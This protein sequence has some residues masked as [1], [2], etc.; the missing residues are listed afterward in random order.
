MSEHFF[1]EILN[2][3]KVDHESID[4]TDDL[5]EYVPEDE[6]FEQYEYIDIERTPVEITK[7]L[8]SEAGPRKTIKLEDKP[9]IIKLKSDEQF[10]QDEES[11]KCS[12]RKCK[13]EKI[14][15]ESQTDLD[16][17]NLIHIRQI[18][19]NECAI[20]NKVLTNSSKLKSHMETRH[21]P[22]I[23][24]CDHCGKFFRSKD[25]CRLHMSHHRKYFL[26]ECRACKKTYK[27]IQSLRY[28]LR[29]HFEHHQCE[30]CG[31]VFEHKKL[32]LG[33]VL[34]KHKKELMMPCR[35]CSRKFARNDA[36]ETHERTIHKDGKVGPRY[37]CDK[38]ESGFDL[39]EDLLNHKTLNH[40]YGV[41]HTCD[42]CGK[43]FRKQ[44][45]LNTH[46]STHKG[47]TIQCDICKIMFTFPSAL[48]K[49]HRQNRC[50][51]PPKLTGVLTKEA[52]AM[53]AKQQLLEI[54][55]NPVAI[56]IEKDFSDMNE[57]FDAVEVFEEKVEVI[58]EKKKPGRKRKL[59]AY[60]MIAEH[61]P[62]MNSS[63]SNAIR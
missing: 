24:T 61:D 9:L 12:N 22:R 6:D 55:V 18:N 7:I 39:R 35:F 33:H 19:N 20:C 11:F 3:D 25:N 44:L 52:I 63:D 30:T 17:H 28:H 42:I 8:K 5:I 58:K 21:L 43:V 37:E 54:T 29:Q 34:S 45:L 31:A 10:N 36:R 56:A 4:E 62:E 32:L 15:F 1:V 51:G 50:K 48:T 57:M 47:K 49:H 26:V 59:I 27:S 41:I 2:L 60:Q 40:N 46:M 23:F 38:C 14:V 16:R 53:I 13:R